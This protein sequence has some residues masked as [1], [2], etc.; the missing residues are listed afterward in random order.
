MKQKLFPGF[1]FMI[2]MIVV[3][4]N[5]IPHHH[6]K[7]FMMH[8]HDLH[9]DGEDHHPEDDHKQDQCLIKSLYLGNPRILQTIR[10]NIQP[11]NVFETGIP[12]AHANLPDRICELSLIHA[13]HGDPPVMN[14]IPEVPARAPPC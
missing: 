12:V 9:H 10:H 7:G 8:H 3:V 6:H 4:H 5:A 14:I 2:M 13:P 11:E 1:L